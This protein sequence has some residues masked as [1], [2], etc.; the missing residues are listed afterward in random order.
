MTFFFYFS[1]S[2]AFLYKQ[3]KTQILLNPFEDV[4]KE[5]LIESGKLCFIFLEEET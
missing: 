5:G 3:E 4:E 2:F 1:L